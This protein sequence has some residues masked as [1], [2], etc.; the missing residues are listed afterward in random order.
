MD[1]KKVRFDIDAPKLYGTRW[2]CQTYLISN[3]KWKICWHKAKLICSVGKLIEKPILSDAF[4]QT[5]RNARSDA[6]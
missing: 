3:R 2:C 4:V 5:N 1:V 6:T